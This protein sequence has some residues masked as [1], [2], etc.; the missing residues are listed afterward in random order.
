MVIEQRRELLNTL[1]QMSE[2]ADVSLREHSFLARYNAI[3][4]NRHRFLVATQ[5]AVNAPSEDMLLS[6]FSSKHRN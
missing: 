4:R 6:L 1:T 3:M 5:K 2:S